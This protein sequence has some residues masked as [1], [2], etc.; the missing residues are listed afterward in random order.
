MVTCKKN[1]I[2]IIIITSVNSYWLSNVIFIYFLN[3]FFLN[4][5]NKAY[6]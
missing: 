4:I 6:K 3:I 1:I 5:Y 2:I